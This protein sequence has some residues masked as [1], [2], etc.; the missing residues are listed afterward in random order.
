MTTKVYLYKESVLTAVSI[1]LALAALFFYNALNWLNHNDFMWLE[2]DVG[3]AAARYGVLRV[4]RT[5]PC[6]VR[7]PIENERRFRRKTSTIPI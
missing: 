5:L 6:A 1:L 2:D 3:G 4:Y 7:I